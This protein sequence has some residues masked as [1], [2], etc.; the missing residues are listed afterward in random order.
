MRFVY[1]CFILITV[2]FTPASYARNDR[3]LFWQVDTGGA[4]VYLLGSIHFADPGF[5]PLRQDIEQAFNYSDHLVVEINLD[6]DKAERYQEL[7]RTRGTYPG[8]ETIR[9]AISEQTYAQL[10]HELRRLGVPIEMVHKLKPGM[11]VLTLTAMQVIKMGYMPELGID[12]Y[13]L[14]KASGYKNII[15]LETVEQQLDLFLNITDAELLLQETLHSMNEADK[16]MFDMVRCWKDG[17]EPCIEKLLF[18]DA[19]V[20]YPAFTKIYDSLFYQR[21]ENMVK[22]IKS[23]IKDEHSYFIIVGAGHL[24]GEEGIPALLRKAGYKVTRL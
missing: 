18:E 23:F 21:N 12:Q 7:V 2:A 17:D 14:N 24:V 8:N 13:F 5:Y 9:Q 1:T 4:K 11:L 6:E 3:A 20:Q 19:L 15:E 16:L 10:Q 22:K